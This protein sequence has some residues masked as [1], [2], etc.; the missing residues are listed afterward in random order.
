MPRGL[1]IMPES[2]PLLGMVS[3]RS[4]TGASSVR[5]A[6]ETSA[7]FGRGLTNVCWFLTGFAGIAAFAFV[8]S[9]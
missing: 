8:V 1:R 5:S 9:L 4:R 6:W 2:P 7:T 3:S